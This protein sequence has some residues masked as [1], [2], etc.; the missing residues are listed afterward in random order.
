M[1]TPKRRN[2]SAIAAVLAVASS[3]FLSSCSTSQKAKLPPLPPAPVSV[4]TV[5]P[6]PMTIGDTYLGQITPYIQTVLSPAA[7]G[8]LSSVNVRPGDIVKAGQVVATLDQSAIVPQQNAVTQ[9]QVAL[10]NA[11]QQYADALAMYNDRTSAQQQ[12]QAAQNAVEQQKLAVQAAEQNLQKAQLQA[13]AALNGGGTPQD[14][15][16]LKAVVAADQQAVDSAKKQL[17]LANSNLQILQQNLETAQ[18][19][20]GNITKEQVQQAYENYQKELAAYNSWQQGAFPGNNPYATPLQAYQSVYNALSSGYNQ[21]QQAQQQYNQGLAAVSQ[22]QTALTSAESALANAQKSLADATP[23]SSTNLAQQAQLTVQQAQT[24]LGQAQAQYQ[25][26]QSSLKLAQA[27]YDD[28]TQAKQALD[29]ALAAV[30][31]NAANLQTAQATLEM[32]VKN[33]QV[34]TPISGYVQAVNAQVGQT[35]GPQTQMITIA[36]MDPAMATVEVPEFDIGK[37]KVGT[38]M[39][40]YVPTLQQTVEGKVLSIHPQLDSATNQYPVDIE[41]DGGGAKLL[42]GMQVEARQETASSQTAILVPADSVLSLQSG[43]QEVFVVQNGVA[44]SRIVQVGAMTSDQY[45][46]T[47]GLQTGDQLVVK[48]QNLL[49]DGDKVKI[50]PDTGST[51]SNG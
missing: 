6:S 49:S 25:A 31:Q 48:G 11:K 41:L 36:S 3:I 18:Q 34:T 1:I 17:D 12:L 10:S 45:E 33:G 9:A 15:T 42:P 4:V 21:L 22:A 44:H 37:L 51:K 13:E 8:P 19:L 39:S 43:A 26:A 7:S 14:L 30:K 24:S 47:S 40:V 46:I 32:Q 27:M 5:K 38:K 20:Y 50:V 2:A 29:N 28:R 23:D 35:V 16:A